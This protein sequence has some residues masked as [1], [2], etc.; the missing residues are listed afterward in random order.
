MPKDKTLMLVTL[1]MNL[2]CSKVIYDTKNI[3][4]SSENR[5]SCSYMDY[6]FVIVQGTTRNTFIYKS[7]I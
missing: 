5:F 6:C 3:T 1:T 2:I 4:S 7:I